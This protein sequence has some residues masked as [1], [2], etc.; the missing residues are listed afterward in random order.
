M[1]APVVPRNYHSVSLLLGD[2][3]VMAA[4]GGLCYTAR[5]AGDTAAD[6]QCDASAQ[7]PDAEIFSPPYLF[8]T[9]G[10]SATRPVINSMKTSDDGTGYWARAGSTVSVTMG[11]TDDLNFS[12]IRLG[13][14]THSVNTDQRR[15]AV[16]ATRNGNIHTFKLPSDYGILLPGYWFVFAFKKGDVPTPSVARVLQVRF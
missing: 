13:S 2:G 16:S 14:A 4:G 11:G 7:H 12:V 8:N 9:D 15:L 6:W 3:R 10:S 1:N 5:G